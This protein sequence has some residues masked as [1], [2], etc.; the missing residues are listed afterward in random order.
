MNSINRI[1]RYLNEDVREPQGLQWNGFRVNPFM[2]T[3]PAWQAQLYQ[4]A[5]EQAL[6]DVEAGRSDWLLSDWCI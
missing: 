2:V 3:T 5:Y 6:R 4:A 1:A